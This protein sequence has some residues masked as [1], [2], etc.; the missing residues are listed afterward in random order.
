M[1]LKKFTPIITLII[2]VCVAG[3]LMFY[4]MNK[5]ESSTP[6]NVSPSPAPSPSPDA[7]TPSEEVSGLEVSVS[8]RNG[9][10]F[11][12]EEPGRY[13]LKYKEDGEYFT[14][15]EVIDEKTTIEDLKLN[16]KE[17]LK[18]TGKAIDIP[19][20]NLH[21]F[22]D[23]ANFH[24]HASNEKS[25]VNLV[26]KEVDGHLVRFTFHFPNKESSE[27]IVPPMLEIMESIKLN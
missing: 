24:M 3:G 18:S 21:P 2:I 9:Y 6:S 12:L 23:E 19:V 25:S 26:V 13:V 8:P 27:G 22:Y 14:R 15:V 20:E 4:S 1:I 10:S 17:Y 5:D 11:G 16:A 7:T